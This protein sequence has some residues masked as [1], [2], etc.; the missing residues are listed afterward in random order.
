MGV[1]L[2]LEYPHFRDLQPF[3][4]T[5]RQVEELAWKVRLQL[6]YAESCH[7]KVPLDLLFNIDGATVNRVRM[8]FQ[9]EVE[10][11]I[12]DEQGVPVL[13]VCDCDPGEWPDLI[14]LSANSGMIRGF[15]ALLRSV[16][17]HELGHGLCDGPGWLG[18]DA[19]A[20]GLHAVAENSSN[21]GGLSVSVCAATFLHGRGWG[22]FGLGPLGLVGRSSVESQPF[23]RPVAGGAVRKPEL[24]AD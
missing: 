16:L 19:G 14:M 20:G 17:A 4:L 12:E 8:T 10:G 6:R 1:H 5:N 22:T 18:V 13:G 3:Y 9:W 2:S 21:F 15:E 7:L 24:V 23:D 11:A